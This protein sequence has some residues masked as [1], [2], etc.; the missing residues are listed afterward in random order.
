MTWYAMSLAMPGLFSLNCIMKSSMEQN[1][2]D[3]IRGDVL[4]WLKYWVVFAYYFVAEA[5]LDTFVAWLPLY[6]ELKLL[7]LIMASPITPFVAIRAFAGVQ[8]EELDINRS[9][10][11]TVFQAICSFNSSSRDGARQLGLNRD[12]LRQNVTFLTQQATQGVKM[13]GFVVS[14]GMTM[15]QNFQGARSSQ[16][17]L[18]MPLE[19]STS[20]F[21]SESVQK[22][23]NPASISQSA[24]QIASSSSSNKI[25]NSK[26]KSKPRVTLIDTDEDESD[27]S[28]SL[29]SCPS[30][31]S[32]RSPS[33]SP[34]KSKAR[35]RRVAS[36]KAAKKLREQR[37]KRTKRNSEQLTTDEY[38]EF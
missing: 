13:A 21:Q 32:S 10:V 37:K 22:C 31:E 1:P 26:R 28:S 16:I 19:R 6:N 24:D 2:S 14:Y 34:V 33:P 17:D 30:M 3:R 23:S 5:I 8:L 4:F 11:Q 35:S 36:I 38:H 29:S 9:P 25:K 20:I 7:T 15:L 12:A 27:I 18:P